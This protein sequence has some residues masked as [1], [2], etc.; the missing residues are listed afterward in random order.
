MQPDET[1]INLHSLKQIF[2]KSADVKFQSYTFEQRQVVFITCDDMV[3][4]QLLNGVIVQRVQHMMSNL[5]DGTIEDAVAEQLHIPDLKKVENI[6]EIGTLIYTGNLLL[7]FE[8]EGLL[9]S[10]NIAEKPNRSPEETKLE[11]PVKGPRDN[12]IEDVSV[13]IAIIRKRLPTNSLCVE[14]FELGKR[15]KTTVALLYFDD[16][17][18]KETLYGIKRQMKKVD[19]DIIFS[20]DLLLES[21][22]I[23][24]A[25]FPRTA[26]TGRPDNAVQSLA[27]G[28][29][30]IFVDGVAYGVILPVNLFLLLKTS[31][32]NENPSVFGSMER[33]L[34]IM[35]MS[36]GITLPAFWLAL[37]TYH[38]DQ[39]PLLLLATVVQANTGLPLPSSVEMLLMLLMF[40]LFRE[41]GLRLPTALG[42]TIGVVGGLIIGDAAIRAGITSPAMIVVI[43]ASTISTFTLVNQS[44]VGSVSILRVFFIILTAFFGLFGFLMSLYFTV[45]YL[46]GIRTFGVPYMNLAAD[47]S[48]K[49]IAKTLL[50]LNPRQ[51]KER[52]NA[53][54]PKDQT[55]SKEGEQ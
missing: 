44:L 22:G 50:R 26:Y 40:E 2:L 38:Q 48:W 39:L 12:F 5:K 35:G 18:S 31:D 37:T 3:N 1:E 6:Q 49:T 21:M 42:G 4:Q 53:L 17:A 11:V 46:A 52:P 25:I 15:T 28:R 23:T 7:Y 20:G 19:T 10:S 24:G 27:R 8:D 36:I 30:L 54:N 33:L 47:L 13:N 16:I 43:A 55:R 29:F 14:K 45:Q 9:F 34:R 41:A 32:D 51:Y